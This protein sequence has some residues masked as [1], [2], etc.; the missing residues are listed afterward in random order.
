MYLTPRDVASRWQVNVR[1]VE[2][3]IQSG[4]LPVVRFG[5]RI[6]RIKREDLEAYEARC[7][8]AAP[9]STPPERDPIK[10]AKLAGLRSRI[11][12]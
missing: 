11:G 4:E 5:P 1:T 6:V 10:D 9:A 3:K 7:S 12:R 2:R 8:E